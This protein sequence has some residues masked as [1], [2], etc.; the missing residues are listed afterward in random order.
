MPSTI[1]GVGTRYFLKLNRQFEETQC[2]HCHNRVKLESYETWYCLCV[3]FIP[4]LP[5]GKKQILGYCPSC[6]RHQVIGFRDWEKIRD[7]AI[8]ETSEEFAEARDN[9]E[10]AM[11]MHGTLLAFQKAAEA[12]RLAEIM[13]NLFGSV[14]AV[15][16]YLGA[17][18]ERAGKGARANA[19][20][21]EAF[22]LAPEDLQ[23]RRA[24]AMV[25][26]EQKKPDEARKLL[27]EFGPETQQFQPP[28]YFALA[29]GYQD[30]GRH[31]EALEIFHML[32]EKQ[33]AV[34]K[35]KEFA[36]A[37]R[38]SEKVQ[39]VSKSALPPDT[40]FRKS[41]I[42]WC[43]CTAAVFAVLGFWSV[44][45]AQHRTLF[46][47]SGLKTPLT[48]QVDGLPVVQVGPNAYRKVSVAE[49]KHTAVVTAPAGR[50]PPIEFEVRANW[51]ERFFSSPVF[52]V[53]PSRSAAVA[54]EQTVYANANARNDH[55][56]K[57]DLRAGDAFTS[58]SHAD[59]HF[60]EFPQQ[61]KVK[62]GSTIT[63][64]RVG[65][66]YESPTRVAHVALMMDQDIA[67]LDQYLEQHLID[68][69]DN[70][71]L[72]NAYIVVGSIRGT[73]DRREKFLEAHLAD[74]PIRVKWHRRYQDL[75]GQFATGGDNVAK[76]AGLVARYDGLLKQ[77]PKDASLLYLR[78]RLE[79]HGR[80]S[81]PFMD[82]ALA[83]DPLHPY[84]TGAKAYSY[85]VQGHPL[86]AVEW[87]RK[88]LAARPGDSEVNDGLK[89]AQLAARDFVALEQALREELKKTPDSLG[90]NLELFEVLFSTQR[91][92]QAEQEYQAL[93]GRLRQQPALQQHA[94]IISR[95]LELPYLY[96]KGDFDNLATRAQQVGPEGAE[97]AFY[98]A[99]ECGQ[100]VDVPTTQVPIFLPYW[101]LCR[102]IVA[103]R[104]NA[105][106]Q[107]AASKA[108]ALTLMEGKAGDEAVAAELL[109]QG[110]NAKWEDIEDLLMQPRLKV[111]LLVALAHEAP[112]MKNQ[113]LD[114]AEKLNHELSFPHHLIR[115][116]IAELRK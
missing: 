41:A 4:V 52:I 20:F 59:Y 25:L 14:A 105:A 39:G 11:K 18:F 43:S 64:T 109:R 88:A 45:V 95:S 29:R 67:Q 98:A 82:Q 78:G 19:C 70:S 93:Q 65:F 71:E 2:P 22:E 114:L 7:A 113:C 46:V 57:L 75:F 107:A 50:F 84:A 90:E 58:F 16:F 13:L 110:P 54:W 60:E 55:V 74:Q 31:A 24:A 9:P 5:L 27:A 53:D 101:H 3:L 66:F 103:R 48:V 44:Y 68:D 32:L 69:P 89:N 28:L 34:A 91:G 33:P 85:L 36:K 106:A 15:Q 63:K 56:N 10:A 111:V 83:I 102:A 21:L 47:V 49:G 23:F 38:K 87:H 72:L 37:L 61:M 115:K 97:Y 35:E 30:A 17:C 62:A 1:N 81:G 86:E 42:M 51:W 92:D 6:T 73:I 40:A 77:S 76:H 108:A 104:L 116:E 100:L 79:P 26:L 96:A 112:Q 80:I 8:S 94:G 12:D 99:L